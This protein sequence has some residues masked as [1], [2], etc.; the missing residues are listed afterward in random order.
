MV[1]NW[2]IGMSLLHNRR[3][4]IK[5]LIHREHYFVEIIVDEYQKRDIISLGRAIDKDT[6]GDY[7]SMLLGLLGQEED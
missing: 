6:R 2:K 3:S 7:E 4:T 5:G 1:S